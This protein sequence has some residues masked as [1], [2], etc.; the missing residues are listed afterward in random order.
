MKT[1]Q[2]IPEILEGGKYKLIEVE[3]VDGEY[4]K[5]SDAQLW[6]DF[7]LALNVEDIDQDR[8]IKAHNALMEAGLWPVCDE[9][10]G[11]GLTDN[12]VTGEV[13][14]GSCNGTGL[15]KP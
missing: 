15:S 6:K 8:V 2:I 5:A 4:V 3:S 12:H 9:C 11:L 14:C 1:Y 7:A 13:E 10:A